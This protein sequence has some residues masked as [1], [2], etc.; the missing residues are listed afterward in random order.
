MKFGWGPIG[1]GGAR[2]DAE[3]FVAAREGLGPEAIL[4]VDVGQIWGE[5]V[6]AAAARLPALENAGA[7]WLEEPFHTGALAAYG[8]PLAARRRGQAGG[9]RGRAQCRRWRSI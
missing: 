1:R 4:L 2:T 5:D 3:H 8:R 6:E 9:R 7:I